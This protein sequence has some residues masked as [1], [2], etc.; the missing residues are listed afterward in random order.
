MKKNV[1]KQHYSYLFQNMKKLLF[2]CLFISL[3]SASKLLITANL[4]NSSSYVVDLEQKNVC[5]KFPDFP[6]ADVAGA[7]GG[8]L[9]QKY[10]FVC[11]GNGAEAINQCYLYRNSQWTDSLILPPQVIFSR[12]VALNDTTVWITGGF[13][14][15]SLSLLVNP[16]E[17]RL[18][19][20]PK[21]K[22][23][24][25]DHCVVNIDGNNVFMISGDQHHRDLRK[26]SVYTFS[27]NT[28]QDGPDLLQTALV[29]ACALVTLSSGKRIIV[30]ADDLT[31]QYLELGTSNGWRYGP[32][33]PYYV[34]QPA[35]VP[36]AGTALLFGF[37]TGTHMLNYNCQN[38]D[39][40]NCAWDELDVQLPFE[41]VGP[42]A[43]FIP[44]E[45]A[46]ACN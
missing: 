33:I 26:T 19:Y 6:M 12:M 38:G 46:P 20:G 2:F 8:L 25:I 27:S 9:M 10:P 29:P 30:L 24:V 41:A 4:R 31:T 43:M 14:N 28:W 5:N 18:I 22:H 15:S 35:M 13:G 32:T 7:S 21:L 17:G 11:N 37:G 16:L 1:S 39:P 44:D 23:G 42:V 40:N 45:I 36:M 34:P 3:T